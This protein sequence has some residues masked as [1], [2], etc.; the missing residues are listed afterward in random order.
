MPLRTERPAT[1][2]RKTSRESPDRVMPSFINIR[3]IVALMMREMTT[4]YGRS[5]G[6]YIWALLE[7]IGVIAI[8]SFVFS[9]VVR[10]PSLGDSFPL[11]YASGFLVF[12]F[13]SEL[14]AF[15]AS[16]VSMNR[17]LLNYPRVTPIDAILARYILQF[18]TLSVASI[19]I[20]SGIIWFQNIHTSYDLMAIIEAICLS[21]LLGLGVGALNTVI[22][23]FI[24]TYQNVWKIIN[25]PMFLISGI[26]FIPED[27]PPGIREWLLYN[28]VMHVTSLMRSGFY[29]TYDAPNVSILYVGGISAV[30]VSLGFFLVY[31]NRTYLIEAP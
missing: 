11:F 16:G 29:P 13:Y 30:C 6:G 5:A 25:R 22:F 8:L 23:A 7:P 14:A 12:M 1:C 21:A 31:S 24:P 10:S 20:L 15:A 28:P 19:L 4:R 27:L 3:V 2:R 17:P 26:F 18:I 9:Y